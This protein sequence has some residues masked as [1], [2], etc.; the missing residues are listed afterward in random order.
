VAGSS[1]YTFKS[2]GTKFSEHRN[3]VISGS[4]VFDQKPIGLKTPLSFG[5]GELFQ[6]HKDIKLVIKDNLKNLILTNHGERLGR[7]DFGA[8]LREMVFDRTSKDNFDGELMTR[9]QNTVNRYMPFVSLDTM[10][11]DVDNHD[12]Q[13]TAKLILR[14]EYSIPH[15]NSTNNGIEIILYIAG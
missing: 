2:A 6:T 15:L 8:N 1:N 7:Y 5:N 14:I 11:S 4:I 3:T 12:N 13:H 9:V 10:S